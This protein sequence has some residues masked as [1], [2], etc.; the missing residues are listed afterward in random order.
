MV[1]VK[2]GAGRDLV[3]EAGEGSYLVFTKERP[4]KGRANRAVI[5]LLAKYLKKPQSALQIIKG[6]KSR[7]KIIEVK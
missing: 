6:L 4:E 1:K 5:R 2:A 3:G 7:Q